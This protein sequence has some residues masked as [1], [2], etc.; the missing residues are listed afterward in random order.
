MPKKISKKH[1]WP[2]LALER[3]EVWGRCIRTQRLQ[4]R[5]TVADLC[6]RLGI[7]P[8]TLRRLE[9]GDPGA[10]VG[11]YMAALLTLGVIDTAVPRLPDV[12]WNEHERSR[13]RL[14][15]KEKAADVD[16]F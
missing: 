11:A 9:Q 16:Y 6:E 1:D 15:Q 10:A 13:V 12:L 2:T 14:S 7:S 4:Q 5:V 8:A 3:L